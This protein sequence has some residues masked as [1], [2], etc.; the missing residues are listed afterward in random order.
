MAGALMWFKDEYPPRRRA[1]IVDQ[2]AGISAISD[3][4]ARA[5]FAAVIDGAP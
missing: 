5:G 3:R 2:A 4:I 1:W